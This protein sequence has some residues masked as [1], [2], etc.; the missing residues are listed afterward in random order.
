MLQT[1]PLVIHPLMTTKNQPI[2][3][4]MRLVSLLHSQEA[5]HSHWFILLA[6]YTWGDLGECQGQS[7]PPPPP[8]KKNKKNSKFIKFTW[9]FS[10]KFTLDPTPPNL[11]IS[12]RETGKIFSGSTHVIAWWVNLVSVYIVNLQ[13]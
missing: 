12:P 8:N 5:L 7:I 9:L 13:L 10:G 1:I 6:P 2:K 3:M 4:S 11:L